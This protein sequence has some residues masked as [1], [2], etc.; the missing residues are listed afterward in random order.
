MSPTASLLLHGHLKKY[1]SLVAEVW[2]DPLLNTSLREAGAQ[3]CLYG[4]LVEL[5]QGGAL[6]NISELGDFLQLL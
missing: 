1:P 3:T 4:S 6:A 2:G 5:K